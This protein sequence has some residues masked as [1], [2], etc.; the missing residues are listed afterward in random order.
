LNDPLVPNRLLH[1]ESRPWRDGKPSLVAELFDE[2]LAADDKRCVC[3]RLFSYLS[4]DINAN[5]DPPTAKV[6]I[7][8]N[9]GHEDTVD[10]VWNASASR[11][12]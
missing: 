12:D 2:H 5:N 1:E 7:R 10:M 6:M 8:C 9:A 11:V 3:G 4:H